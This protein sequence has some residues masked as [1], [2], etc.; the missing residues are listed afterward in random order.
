MSIKI[1]LL[2]LLLMREIHI[3]IILKVTEM[4]LS[5]K[6]GICVSYYTDSF[7]VIRA[8]S[9]QLLYIYIYIYIFFFFNSV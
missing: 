4:K 3:Y 2:L 9:E 8:D 6:V 7:S 1:L 5:H